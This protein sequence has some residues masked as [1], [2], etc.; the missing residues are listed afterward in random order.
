MPQRDTEGEHGSV[1][2]HPG[3]AH[4][5]RRELHGLGGRKPIASV[6]SQNIRE[7]E[8]NGR[9]VIMRCGRSEEHQHSS[10]AR[11]INKHQGES[12]SSGAGRGIDVEDAC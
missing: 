11:E 10:K 12:A 8:L 5:P 3:T 2:S 4:G 9:Q 7:I 6:S 1:P